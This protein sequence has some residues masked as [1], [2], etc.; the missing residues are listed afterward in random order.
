MD[1]QLGSGGKLLKAKKEDVV[2]NEWL[3]GRGLC[4]PGAAGGG[5]GRPRGRGRRVAGFGGRLRADDERFL[6]SHGPQ[7]KVIF[8]QTALLHMDSS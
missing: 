3:L 1:G 8:M 4:G 5:G 6:H 7:S 2:R